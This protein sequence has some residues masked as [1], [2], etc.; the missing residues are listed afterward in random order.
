MTR[1][2]KIRRKL[3]AIQEEK[4]VGLQSKT[5][6]P[7]SPISMIL[8]TKLRTQKTKDLTRMSNVR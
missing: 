7:K 3:A 4:K 2:T 6:T 1:A 8:S 5:L